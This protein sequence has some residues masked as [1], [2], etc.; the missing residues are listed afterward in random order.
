MCWLQVAGQQPGSAL[1]VG[2]MLWHLVG[3][4]KSRTVP[5]NRSR[6]GSLG[7]SRYAASR[8]LKALRKAG[9]VAFEDRT[10]RTAV[11]TVLDVPADVAMDKRA[12]GAGTS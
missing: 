6:L 2:I 8:G 12:S 3:L 10:G 5:V 7:V 9:L 4:K 1:H 11:V